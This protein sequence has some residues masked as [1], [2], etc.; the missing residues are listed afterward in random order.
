[1]RVLN[2]GSYPLLRFDRG[3][4]FPEALAAWCA[5]TGVGGA[6]LLCG[7]GMMADVELGVYDGS[8]YRRRVFPGP[9]EVLSLSGNVSM[10]DGKP[11]VHVHAVLG[12]HEFEARGG[13]LF[14]GTVAVTLEV[15]L[16]ITDTPMERG[17]A[18]GAFRPLQAPKGDI[19][20]T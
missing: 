12:S 6:V 7:V 5:E 14:G 10:L 9:D 11:F 16:R 17:E 15:A 8:A 1:M 18:Q 3:E 20:D 2:G 19:A 4:R 13:H